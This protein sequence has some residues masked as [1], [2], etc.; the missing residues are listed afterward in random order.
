MRICWSNM[1][2]I[3]L[4]IVLGTASMLASCGQK[5]ALYLPDEP[6]VMPQDDTT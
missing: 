5:G 3:A 6:P 1:L 4:V 2:M